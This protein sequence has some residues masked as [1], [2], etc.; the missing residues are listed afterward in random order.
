M[1]FI[2]F[3][4][5]QLSCN[6]LKIYLFITNGGYNMYMEYFCNDYLFGGQYQHLWTAQGPGYRMEICI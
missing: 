5:S 6:N 2:A 3:C 1:Q 4:S